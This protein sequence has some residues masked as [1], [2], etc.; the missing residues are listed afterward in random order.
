MKDSLS[1]SLSFSRLSL[2]LALH[3]E[4]SKEQQQQTAK[5][6][7]D[8]RNWSIILNSDLAHRGHYPYSLEEA[9]EIIGED[10]RSRDNIFPDGQLV[11]LV[12][13]PGK[14]PG[15]EPDHEAGREPEWRP[16]GSIHTIVSSEQQVKASFTPEHTGAA[17]GTWNLFTNYGRLSPESYDPAGSR[18]VCFAIQTDQDL[19]RKK[20]DIKPADLIIKGVRVLAFAEGKEYAELGKTVEFSEEFKKVVGKYPAI[21]YIN[22]LTRLSGFYQSKQRY[23]ELTALDYAQK[24]ERL[25]FHK[26]PPQTTFNL[27]LYSLTKKCSLRYHCSRGARIEQVIEK[28]RVH[29]TA[30]RGYGA[31]VLYSR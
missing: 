15:K 26:D 4:L 11:L 6:Y 30:S 25:F 14:E 18:W 17:D 3:A 19:D 5:I 8:E 12:K 21:Q 10:A 27:D 29:D 16:I 13:E 7:L 22:P 9:V 1:D 23:P 2:C 20:W 31:S 24:I 28:F